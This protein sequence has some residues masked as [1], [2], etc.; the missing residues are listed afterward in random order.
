MKVDVPGVKLRVT[1]GT[2]ECACVLSDGRDITLDTELK[3]EI[4]VEHGDDTIG[5]IVSDC[6]TGTSNGFKVSELQTVVSL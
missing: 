6:E 1:F 5:E 3:E 2:K 4:V